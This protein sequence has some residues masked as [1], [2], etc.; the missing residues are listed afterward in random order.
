MSDNL[1]EKYL[2]YALNDFNYMSKLNS[3]CEL[4]AAPCKQSYKSKCNAFIWTERKGA[5]DA[6]G[7]TPTM[8]D[9]VMYDYIHD[10]LDSHEMIDLLT[11]II[12][13][14]DDKKQKE[15]DL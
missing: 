4:C 15:I 14:T 1:C 8:S 9:E 13:V 11:I 6:L 5:L 2:R 7:D 10:Y 3:I 12:K